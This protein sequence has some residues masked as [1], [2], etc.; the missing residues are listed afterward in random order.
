MLNMLSLKP[1]AYES[2]TLLTIVC[3][4]SNVLLYVHVHVHVLVHVLVHVHVHV[5]VYVYEHEHV[6]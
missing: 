4:F 2:N 1:L 6:P 5:Y 3:M